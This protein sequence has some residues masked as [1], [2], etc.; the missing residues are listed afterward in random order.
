MGVGE[1][2]IESEYFSLLFK[3]DLHGNV[4]YKPYLPLGVI[5]CYQAPGGEL[6]NEFVNERF[7]GMSSM[8]VTKSNQMVCFN[9][10]ANRMD[11]I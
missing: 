3:L 9:R 5:R 7:V 10:R 11:I 2:P 8:A 6:I 4:F 1:I